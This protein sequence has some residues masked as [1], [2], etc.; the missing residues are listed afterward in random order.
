MPLAEQSTFIP[1]AKPDM[2]FR[3]KNQQLSAELSLAPNVTRKIVTIDRI[4]IG[5]TGWRITYRVG[6]P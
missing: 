6:T 4:E 3:E 5:G 2:T 1:D